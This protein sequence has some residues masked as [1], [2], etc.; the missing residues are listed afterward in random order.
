MQIQFERWAQSHGY[1]LKR[2]NRGEGYYRLDTQDLWECWQAAWRTATEMID[3]CLMLLG[4]FL[5][6]S[7]PLL[8]FL[9]RNP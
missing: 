4:L 1:D 8:L 6:L 7:W 9:F 5:V 3:G 2:N